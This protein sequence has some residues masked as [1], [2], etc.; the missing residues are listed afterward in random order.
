MA[1]M[2]DPHFPLVFFVNIGISDS[3]GYIYTL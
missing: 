3:L 1:F 2:Q